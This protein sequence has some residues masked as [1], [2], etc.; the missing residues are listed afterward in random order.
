MSPMIRKIA[1]ILVGA[2]LVCGMVVFAGCDGGSNG[3]N[4]NSSASAK[5]SNK[6]NVNTAKNTNKS[7]A[8]TGNANYIK[9]VSDDDEYAKG[10]HHATV[11]VEG[12][13]PF[14]IELDADNAP[15]SVSN[16]C[17]LANEGFYDGLTFYRFQDKFCMQGGSSNNGT[18]IV[19]DGLSQ[20]KGEFSSNKVKNKLADKFEKGTV[21]M[22]RSN[23]PNS[24][25][26]TFFVTLDSS[27]MVSGSLN[28]NYAAF[29]TIDDEG[30]EI[31]DQIVADHVA[32]GDPSMGVIDDVSKQAKIE[33]IKITD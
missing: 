9:S 8:Q 26:S 13:E 33:S 6:D 24:A 29:G 30:M 20:I 16:F 7:S 2:L 10:I 17:K 18:A 14:V 11:T 32:D 15:I 21:A 27:D 12:Y 4:A 28:G 25:T 1:A 3:S 22:A 5:A 23:D 19:D 31:V